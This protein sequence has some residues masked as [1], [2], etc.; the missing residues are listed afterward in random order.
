MT[1]KNTKYI[2]EF[3]AGDYDGMGR[4]DIENRTNY[5]GMLKGNK[6][7]GQ[8]FLMDKE[9]ALLFEGSWKDNLRHGQGKQNNFA[10]N[11]T[12]QGVWHED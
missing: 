3:Q 4:L 8:G 12:I 9:N 2:G 7:H 6:R 5:V 11:Q 10:A 1:T